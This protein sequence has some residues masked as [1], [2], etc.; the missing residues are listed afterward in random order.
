MSEKYLIEEC[1]PNSKQ[2]W[3]T[4]A[5]QELTIC[6]EN[7]IFHVRN[8]NIMF[9][10]NECMISAFFIGDFKE[11]FTWES[12]DFMQ[13]TLVCGPHVWKVIFGI[14]LQCCRS[15]TAVPYLQP[16]LFLYGFTVPNWNII[17]KFLRD[18]TKRPRNDRTLFC[19]SGAKVSVYSWL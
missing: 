18:S 19:K 2:N 15:L 10:S 6:I 7:R 13:W 1:M 3:L 16:K 12:F 5:T 14:K 4:S 9:S 17:S 8:Q 11:K